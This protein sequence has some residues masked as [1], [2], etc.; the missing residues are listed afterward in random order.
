MEKTVVAYTDQK[1]V[2]LYLGRWLRSRL[3]I[4]SAARPSSS[5]GSDP[6]RGPTASSMPPAY[7]RK[8]PTAVE[9]SIAVHVLQ[10]INMAG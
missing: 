7:S 8:A 1:W 2:L 6:G 10:V 3:V 9:P 4:Q 5:T